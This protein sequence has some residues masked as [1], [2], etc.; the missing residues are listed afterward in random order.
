MDTG[1]IDHSK[2]GYSSQ[3]DIGRTVERVKDRTSKV[4]IVEGYD[5][6]LRVCP[7]CGYDNG[8]LLSGCKSCRI[9]FVE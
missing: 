4:T 3:L 2:W 9:S 6:R 5:P 8:E 1:K 7:H